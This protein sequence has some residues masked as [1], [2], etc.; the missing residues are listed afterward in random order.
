MTRSRT[1][2]LQLTHS[3]AAF[4]GVVA[5]LSSAPV[6]AAAPGPLATSLTGDALDSYKSA[7]LLFDD[8]DYA[9]A[10]TKFRA[11][12][13]S[14]HDARLLWNMAA[15]EKELRHYARASEL[16]DRF[17]HDAT[18]LDPTQIAQARATQAAFKQFFSEVTFAIE[19]AG[20]SVRLDNEEIGQS[21]IA[22]PVAVD[23]GTHTLHVQRDGY[24]AV[25]QQ[26]S[27]TGSS[28]PRV[29]VSLSPV[30]STAFLAV[31]V[32]DP[33]YSVLVDTKFVGKGTWEGAV[34]PGT[35]QV[36]VEGPG[37]QTKVTDVDLALGEHRSLSP[38]LDDEKRAVWPWFVGGGA[39]VVAGLAVGGYFLFR[40]SDSTGA[41]PD[42]KLGTVMARRGGGR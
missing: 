3:V 25:D 13:D 24:T 35:H 22:K 23:I 27:I 9:G 30:A 7:K 21:P 5:L 31:Q 15:C 28:S 29:A 41:F 12:Y 20:A 16:V 37:K 6:Q 40:P 36:T 34:S 39:V 10:V 38:H 18:G 2:R 42:S 33:A 26:L 11:A 32:E 17:L 14:S 8:H 19:P 4:A 1:L